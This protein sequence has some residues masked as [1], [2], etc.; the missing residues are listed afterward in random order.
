MTLEPSKMSPYS[1]R[2]VSKARTCWM[3]SDHCWS[4]GRGQPERLVPRRELDGPGPGVL[5]QRD[6]EHL[7]DDPLHVVLRLLLGQAERVDLDAVAEAAEL[8]VL[9]A[10]ALAADAVP[11]AR[12]RPHLARLFDEADARV[13]EE[14][15][16][17]DDGRQIGSSTLPEA[18]TP[19][20]TPMAVASANAISWTGVAPAS[21]RW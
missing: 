8:G 4:Q 16:A 12:E 15:D 14:A 2:S 6:P 19:S 3:R 10:V 9:D 13:H 18:R 7:E 11:H 5:R 21:W 20:S 17:A 1:S